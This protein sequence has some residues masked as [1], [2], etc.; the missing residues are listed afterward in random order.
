MV[1][2]M[3]GATIA[4]VMTHIRRS[5]A[6]PIPGLRRRRCLH[7]GMIVHSAIHGHRRSRYLGRHAGRAGQHGCRRQSLEGQR[8]QQ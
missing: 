1:A 4:A 8:Q 3:R 2:V 6:V 5:C 7:C